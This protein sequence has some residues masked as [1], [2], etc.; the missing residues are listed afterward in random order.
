M[1]TKL[2]G[3]IKGQKETEEHQQ[4]ILATAREFPKALK[5]S[6][7]VYR[8][9]EGLG[10]VPSAGSTTNHAQRGDLS[11]ETIIELENLEAIQLCEKTVCKDIRMQRI[12][13]AKPREERKL[14]EDNAGRALFEL[15]E[16]HKQQLDKISKGFQRANR[17]PTGSGYP[18][19][20]FVGWCRT[21]PCRNKYEGPASR[22]QPP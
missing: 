13:K 10:F 3:I 17:K 6:P 8:Y 16:A 11:L 22:E 9:V 18:R 4:G 20:K 21:A 1:L 7:L 12:A 14:A 5:D 19:R 15:G 2:E